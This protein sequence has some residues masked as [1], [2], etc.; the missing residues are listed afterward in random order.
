MQLFF[1]NLKYSETFPYI[2]KGKFIIIDGIDG[3]GKGVILDVVKDNYGHIFDLR[4]HTK[5]NKAFPKI[6][7]INQDVIISAEPTNLYVGAAIRNEILRGEHKYSGLTTA[8]AFALDREILYNRFIIPA[9]KAGKTI[10]QE[11]GIVSSLVYQPV[12]HEKL[13]LRD[14]IN[15]PGNKLAIKNAPNFVI[16]VKANPDIIAARVKKDEKGI[17]DNLFFQRKIEA[18][19]ESEWLKQVFERFGSKVLYLDGN[20]S[21]SELKERALKLFRDYVMEGQKTLD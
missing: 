9:L 6:E 17:F 12:Q 20:C 18:R 15:I 16:I 2:M 3:S 19:F 14:L 11:R 4:K 7:E 13:T 10:I 5:E 21:L 8:H 1:T